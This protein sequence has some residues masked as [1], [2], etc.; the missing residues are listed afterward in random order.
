MDAEIKKQALRR[1]TYGLH[2]LTAAHAGEVAAGTVNWVSQCSFTP[3]LVM[4]ALKAD[5]RLHAVFEQAGGGALNIL[6]AGQKEIAA[7]FFKPTRVEAGQ[8]NGYACAAG[9]QTGAPLLT[10]A[11]AWLELRAAASVKQGDHTV[12]VAE[13]VGAGLPAPE[14]QALEM[15]DTGWFYGG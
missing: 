5:S 12:W 6:G 4:L 14:A 3:P 8:L 9:A 2:I 1:L 7:A 10:A 13:V 11:P 15:W